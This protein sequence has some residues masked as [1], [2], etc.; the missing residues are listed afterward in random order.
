M[1]ADGRDK[2]SARPVGWQPK[3]LALKPRWVRLN[4]MI[5]YFLPRA[6][7]RPVMRLHIIQES[8]Q[9][10]EP[11]RTPEDPAMH[12]DRHH[13]RCGFTFGIQHIKGVFEIGIELF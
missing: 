13:F 5:G 12:A 4:P 3:V 10:P 2:P 1:L 9:C 8:L 6:D 11:P 7:P